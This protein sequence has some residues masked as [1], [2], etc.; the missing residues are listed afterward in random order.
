VTGNQITANCA[1]GT[2]AK[3][4]YDPGEPE[5]LYPVRR[6]RAEWK[7]IQQNIGKS[8]FVLIKCGISIY[9]RVFFTFNEQVASKSVEKQKA[10]NSKVKPFT[11]AVLIFDSVSEMSAEKNLPESWKFLKNLKNFPVY[12]FPFSKA[13]P[14][15][16]RENIIPMTYGMHLS[17]QVELIQSASLKSPSTHKIFEKVQENAIWRDFSNSGFITFFGYDS[18][19][20]FLAKSLGPSILTDHKFINFYKI[21]QSVYRFTDMTEN[22]RCA[23]DQGGHKPMLDATLKYYQTY[24]GYLRFGYTHISSAHENTGNIKT[25]DLDLLDF[26]QSFLETFEKN[27]EDFVLFIIGDHGR[28]NMQLRFDP[29]GYWDVLNPMLFVVTS[30]GVDGRI[31]KKNTDKLIGRFDLHLTLKDLVKFP[32]GGMTDQEYSKA[33]ASYKA[34]DVVS[35]FREEI[36]YSRTCEDIGSNKKKCFCDTYKKVELGKKFYGNIV[37]AIIVAVSD[38]L[39]EDF[40]DVQEC[41]RPEVKEILSAYHYEIREIDD[42]LESVYVIKFNTQFKHIIEIENYFWFDKRDKFLDDF[43]K[44]SKRPWKKIK[45]EDMN[46]NV[47]IWDLKIGGSCGKTGCFCK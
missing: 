5:Y 39:V 22:H 28:M 34:S 9:T 6:P 26:L 36:S 40:K 8:Q 27:Q 16:T 12:R 31:L 33:K 30:E 23:G 24:Q 43:A 3:F 4:Y 38:H 17:D 13:N 2:P 15:T 37:A 29:R 44:N 35:L 45:V 42:G 7:P 11:V 14:F 18:A 25:V 10:I 47:L 21:S 19:F 46:A 20:D 1:D 41:V 32:Y